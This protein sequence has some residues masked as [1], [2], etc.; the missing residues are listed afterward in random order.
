MEQRMRT[1]CVAG[2]SVLSV[3][4]LWHPVWL[5]GGQLLRYLTGH[6]DQE[7]QRYPLK[8]AW[9]SFMLIVKRRGKNGALGQTFH[10]S[11]SLTLW[12]CDL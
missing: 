3:E 11:R 8:S 10:E 5:G 4:S 9:R 12:L 7:S 6:S 1:L 2:S